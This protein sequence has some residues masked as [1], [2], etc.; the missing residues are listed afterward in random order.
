MME[1]K[2]WQLG[3][4]IFNKIYPHRQC[5]IQLNTLTRIP[6]SS[7]TS[8]IEIPKWNIFVSVVLVI[9]DMHAL[10]LFELNWTGFYIYLFVQQKSILFNKDQDANRYLLIW[11]DSMG[12]TFYSIKWHYYFY[13]FNSN[14][15]IRLNSMKYH[16]VKAKRSVF[17]KKKY[18]VES[19]KSYFLMKTHCPL[20][21]LRLSWRTFFLLFT[22]VP[23]LTFSPWKNLRQ[24]VWLQYVP[25]TTNAHI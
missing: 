25:A 7:S 21:I 4:I 6:N 16:P 19:L 20:P 23:K 14:Y 13:V 12:T 5:L 22:F 9:L 1:H 3:H 24:N 2:L 15:E 11:Y 8:L 17:A 18:T 10:Y